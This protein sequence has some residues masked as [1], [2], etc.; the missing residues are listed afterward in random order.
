MGAR[1]ILGLIPTSAILYAWVTPL[2][3][4]ALEQSPSTS[5]QA[6]GYIFSANLYGTA[7]GGLLAI[8]VV[9]RFAWQ[10]ICRLLLCAMV[11]AD[12]TSIWTSDPSWLSAIRF[13]HGVAGGVLMGCAAAVIAR[14][15]NPE[16]T[17]S[18]AFVL[19]TLLGGTILFGVSPLIASFGVFPVWICLIVV[20]VVCVFLIPLLHSY[21]VAEHTPSQGSLSLT[22]SSAITALAVLALFAYQATQQGAW[23]YTFELG[24]SF[25]LS[26]AFL[27]GASGTAVWIGAASAAFTAYWS[28]RSGYRLPIL[29]GGLLSAC[30]VAVMS[31]KS[32]V[33]YAMG[34]IGWA[35]FYTIITVY[36]LAMF[37]ALDPSGRF[38]AVGNFASNTGLA[39]GPLVAASLLGS[40]VGYTTLLLL[41]ASGMAMAT[42][43]ALV[44]ARYLEMLPKS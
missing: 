2:I 40:G 15:Y 26:D 27:G 18:I 19:Q 28:M 33:A 17:I 35:F 9:R 4:S 42:L 5:A 11:L 38:A 37:A 3:V 16:R 14:T 24:Q 30:A 23:V 31:N 43:V 22:L 25:G 6:A 36:L 13:A 34:T 21:P 7:F 1:V 20:S 12:G 41:A 29:A 32:A 44:P 8:V 39:T 10:P